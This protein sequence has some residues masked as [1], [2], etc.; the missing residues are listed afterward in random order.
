MPRPPLKRNSP[1]GFIEPCI[2]A[3]TDRVPDGPLWVHELKH[4]GYRMLAKCGSTVRLFTRNGFDWTR[5]YPR[6]AA[7]LERLK[8][9]SATIDGEAVWL[10][11]DGKSHFDRLHARVADNEVCL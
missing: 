11:A 3:L 6:I 7:A 2:P 10:G 8:V 4:D 5:R 1:P 9:G